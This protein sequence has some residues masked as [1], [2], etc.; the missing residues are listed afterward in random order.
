[1]NEIKNNKPKRRN[2][3]PFNTIFFIVL[4]VFVIYMLVRGFIW[5]WETLA[6]WDTL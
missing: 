2:N 4:A 5:A 3:A 1:M 6:G